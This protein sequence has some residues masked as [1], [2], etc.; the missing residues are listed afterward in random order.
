VEKSNSNL[1]IIY[2][3]NGEEIDIFF[4]LGRV[5]MSPATPPFLFS[6]FD[7]E[8]SGGAKERD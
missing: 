1:I 7:I 4:K 3:Y 5:E 8:S 6:E 2:R